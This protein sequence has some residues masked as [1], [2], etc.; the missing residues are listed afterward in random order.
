M[1]RDATPRFASAGAAG[2]ALLLVLCGCV[3]DATQGAPR[4]CPVH[5]TTLK[6]DTVRVVYGLPGEWGIEPLR[7]ARDTRFPYAATH[8][9][10]GCMVGEPKLYRV[11]Y[12][13]DCRT[14][15]LAYYRGEVPAIIKQLQAEHQASQAASQ[16]SAATGD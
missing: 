14:A 3:T 15:R 12:C 9:D 7:V 5:G 4:T 11:M 1:F 2:A 6:A 16:P 13:R 8:V 10:G